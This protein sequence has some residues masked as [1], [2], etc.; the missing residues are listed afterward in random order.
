MAGAQPVY[1]NERK[2][3]SEL[4]NETGDIAWRLPYGSGGSEKVWPENRTGLN[5]TF[6]NRSPGN[7]SIDFDWDLQK[8][9]LT[10]NL[11]RFQVN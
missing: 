5:Q 4:I 7:L 10:R 2:M 9:L 8:E 1:A 11:Q 3:V 6:C